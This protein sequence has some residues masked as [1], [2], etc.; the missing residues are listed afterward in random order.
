MSDSS[1]VSY[2]DNFG[3]LT[4][5]PPTLTDYQVLASCYSIK[6]GTSSKDSPFAECTLCKSITFQ[7]NS[8][9]ELI[10]DYAF[11]NF[12]NLQSIDFTNCGKL[13]IIP[14]YCFADSKQLASIIL[15]ESLQVFSDHCLTNT[16]SLKYLRIPDSV[17]TFGY[18]MI[19]NSGI[20]QLD[21]SENCKVTDYSNEKFSNSN[22]ESIFISKIVS[23]IDG[24]SFM[25]SPSLN[26]FV[27]DQ[28]NPNYKCIN[29]QTIL[30]SKED[31]LIATVMK[32]DFVVPEGVTTM[33]YACLRGAYIT[34]ITFPSYNMIS[35]GDW[36]FSTLT[37]SSFV[38]PS[39]ITQ[40]P[41]HAFSFNDNLKHVTLTP[42]ITTIGMYAFTYCRG[43]QTI[44]L[45]NVTN[46]SSY[47]FS[48]CSKLENIV[49]PPSLTNLGKSIFSY[50]PLLKIDSSQ[51][52]NF[53]I[54][55]GMLFIPGEDTTNKNTLSEFF[56]DQKTVNL[57]DQCEILNTNVFSSK[58][59]DTVVFNPN[60][61]KMIIRS[62]A[63]SSST[64]QYIELPQNLQEIEDEAFF[65]CSKLEKVTF[66]D[67]TITSIPKQCFYQCESLSTIIFPHSLLSIGESAFFGCLNLEAINL[68]L[69]NIKSINDSAFQNSG[70][71]TLD[72]PSS[73]EWIGKYAFMDSQ[74][75][76]INFNNC[77][78][79]IISSSC[80]EGAVYLSN[81]TLSD[82][83]T[84]IEQK[85]FYG[86]QMLKTVL[87]P[88]NI[89]T[90]DYSSFQYC[91]ELE[92]IQL[93][94]ECNLQVIKPLSFSNC[95]KLTKIQLDPEDKKF[96]FYD[97]A[98][99]NYNFTKLIIFLP[100]SPVTMYVVPANVETINDN[101]FESCIN[102]RTIIIPYGHIETIRFRAFANCT[103]LSSIYLPQGIK[104]IA[105]Q[106]FAECPSLRCGSIV[107]FP[108][109]IP[110]LENLTID[111]IFYSTNCP[112]IIITPFRCHSSMHLLHLASIMLIFS[113]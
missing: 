30:N 101:A 33:G 86:C 29:K 82:S 26:E 74:L 14:S 89:E 62:G 105:S 87:L 80:F 85:A 36:C 72:L 4:Y 111:P 109:V 6:G 78:I 25:L 113:N 66:T 56:G 22:L 52:S 97:Y 96:V 18:Q 54:V 21:I 49:F 15:P 69:I 110:L 50:C 112:S 17:T 98:L 65:W 27:L 20:T 47:A 83:I 55:D 95:P 79:D 102:L 60:S 92:S 71:K 34:T 1:G 35:F 10:G 9:L 59:I 53:H 19:S 70:I 88:K 13:K 104:T 8:L 48:S 28:Q 90:L 76:Q 37:I 5:A 77:P 43:L 108:D 38:F 67:T 99:L 40:V 63:F 100:S 11:S 61:A 91:L 16:E 73:T 57:P 84:L 64:I 12:R 68:T 3:I 45:M 32:G 58:S 51:N 7:E 75:S 81:I 31:Q 94:L 103:K 42:E 24:S 106:V 93:P 41:T 107:T 2:Q 23:N 46:I 39:G 44:D